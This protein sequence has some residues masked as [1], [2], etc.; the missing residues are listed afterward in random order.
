VET[1]EA[2]EHRQVFREQ[3]HFGLGFES[4][5][6]WGSRSLACSGG[7]SRSINLRSKADGSSSPRSIAD[8]RVAVIPVHAAIST[9]RSP[10]ATRRTFQNKPMCGGAMLLMR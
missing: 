10:A 9:C 5:V 8:K 2:L 3:I 4:Q 7:N 1:P 6:I